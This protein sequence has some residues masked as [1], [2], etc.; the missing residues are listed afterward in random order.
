MRIGI[1][2]YWFNRGQ[3]TV[4]RYIRS[5]F[6]DLGNDTFVLAR[7]TL[8]RFDLPRFIDTTD[9][10]NQQ[11]ITAA[12]R[13]EIPL[14][15]YTRWAKVNSL[16]VAFF[17]Q[18]YQFKQIAKLRSKG[19]KTVGR[20]V[21]ESFSEKHV[22]KAKGAFDIIYS[23]TKCEQERYAEFGIDSPL[24]PWGCHPEL[25]EIC[26][27]KPIDGIYFYYPGGYLSKRKPTK[28]VIQ[29]FSQVKSPDIRLILKVQTP[30][31]HDES[32]GDIR[33]LDPRIKVITADLPSNDHY[34]LF[35]S[36][37]VCLAPSRWE[38]LG[39]HLYEAVSF[40][41]PTITN[42][43][44][45]MNEIVRDQYNGLLVTSHQIGLASSGIPA[46]EP[47]T[48]GLSRAIEVLSEPRTINEFSRKTMGMRNKV[49]SWD[50][51]I[52]GFQSLLYS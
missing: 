49:L 14:K 28:A 21:W 11:G 2:S 25:N 13:Y 37:H 42:D 3:G 1:V 18:N 47:D 48:E 41:L 36:C 6:K 44:P 5:I 34:N 8:D 46:Y 51:T 20:F 35:A 15:E 40:A 27:E 22:K 24:I 38:G 4:G 23:L 45:P 39:L 19:I 7:P 29:A 43:N 26:S 17:D 32:I 50:K 33:A 16:D 30:K 12:S 52:A 10:W 9:V 31:R